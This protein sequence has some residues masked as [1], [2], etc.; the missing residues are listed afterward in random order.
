[1][2]THGGARSPAPGKRRTPAEMSVEFAAE[3][4]RLKEE[5]A[6]RQRERDL[7]DA[8][9]RKPAEQRRADARRERDVGRARQARDDL[10]ARDRR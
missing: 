4:R 5:A 3:Q 1:M 7:A 2:S 10:P 8:G 9:P 6:R